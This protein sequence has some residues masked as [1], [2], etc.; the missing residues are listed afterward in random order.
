MKTVWAKNIRDQKN[1]SLAFYRKSEMTKDSRL[2]IV[3]SNVY[4][5]FVDGRL[6][7]YGPARAA[8]GYTRRDSYD[9]SQYAGRQVHIVVEV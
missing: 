4:R 1:H 8:H 6:T 3:A 5:L 9:L 2:E 7:G